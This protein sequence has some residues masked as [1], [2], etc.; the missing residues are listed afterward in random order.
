MNPERTSADKISVHLSLSSKKI[1]G[2][3]D[4]KILETVCQGFKNFP[5]SPALYCLFQSSRRIHISCVFLASTESLPIADHWLASYP[6]MFSRNGGS[7]SRVCNIM[8]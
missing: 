1:D 8:Q 5:V 6:E 7:D 3:E 2:T 4:S